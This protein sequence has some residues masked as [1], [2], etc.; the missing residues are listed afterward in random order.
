M[1]L[2]VYFVLFMTLTGHSSANY[3]LCKD[4]VG[5]Q[6]LQKAIDYAC[7]AG[8]DCA[9]IT[10]NGPC[11]QPNTIKDHCNYAVNS[12]FQRKGQ[13]QGSCDFSGAAT[14][15]VTG[16]PTSV[17][18]C[19]FPSSPS[20][21]GTSTST[22]P[23]TTTPGTS[24]STLTPP[25]GT[26]PIGTSPGTGT[27]TGTGMGSSTGTGTGTGMGSGTG[28]GTGTTTGS[29]NVFGISPASSTGPGFTD[30]NHGVVHVISTKML[31]LSLVLTFWLVTFLRF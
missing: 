13:V 15:S 3:C 20:N 17:S 21:A 19:V 8:A 18:S 2:L 16:P 5:E 6:A 4:G 14:P 26:T 1:A 24:P 9:P 22:T 28:M 23:T 11:F 7:G 29:P 30:P 25:T 27:G 12:Y 10:Q 31:L